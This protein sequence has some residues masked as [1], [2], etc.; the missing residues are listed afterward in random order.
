LRA[1]RSRL[2]IAPAHA[3]ESLPASKRDSVATTTQF[4]H[5]TRGSWIDEPR[6]LV[7]E[8]LDGIAGRYWTGMRPSPTTRHI[9][10]MGLRAS[11]KSTVG[12]RLASRLGGEFIDLDDRTRDALGASSVREAFERAGEARFR[13]AEA[14][15]L[16]KE[17][18]A[19]ARSETRRVLALGGGTPT[20]PGVEPLLQEAR[21]NG[22]VLVAFLDPPA[23]VLAERLTKDAGAR[24]SL[25][26]RGVVEEVAEIALA[27]RE[28]Y[29]ALADFRFRDPLDPEALVSALVSIITSQVASDSS[30]G[31]A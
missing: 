26:G 28:R 6:D 9:V 31:T 14:E 22:C 10:L 3:G 18:D 29:A 19:A 12:P 17:L 15:A 30:S 27:R 4:P 13:H 7:F 11:G 16:A 21:R 2:A 5:T 8:P 1:A 23:S 20:A 24:P 25:T